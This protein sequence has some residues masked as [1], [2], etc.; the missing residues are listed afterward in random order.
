MEQVLVTLQGDMGAG[1]SAK[2][3]ELAPQYNAYLR[4]R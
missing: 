4:L 1:K 2:A 3:K